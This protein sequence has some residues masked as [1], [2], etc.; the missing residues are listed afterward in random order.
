MRIFRSVLP[1]SSVAFGNNTTSSSKWYCVMSVI[2]SFSSLSKGRSTPQ[3][4]LLSAH[5]LQLE[6]VK[7]KKKMWGIQRTVSSHRCSYLRKNRHRL[8]GCCA[9]LLVTAATK[10]ATRRRCP[11]S[12]ANPN[13]TRQMRSVAHPR[14]H[15]HGRVFGLLLDQ[16]VKTA[17]GSVGG[18]EE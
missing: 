12:L 15:V 1:N 5:D 18:N 2:N 14:G 3:S 17:E 6:I 16:G 7:K 10:T 13:T 11:W 8:F 9:L 4:D